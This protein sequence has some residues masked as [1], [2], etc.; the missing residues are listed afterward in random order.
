MPYTEYMTE[1]IKTGVEIINQC[2][3]IEVDNDPCVAIEQYEQCI[4]DRAS[5]LNYKELMYKS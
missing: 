4:N 2:T 5:V 3:D 1:K